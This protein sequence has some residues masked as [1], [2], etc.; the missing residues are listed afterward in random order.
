MALNKLIYRFF[1]YQR[2]LFWFLVLAVALRSIWDLLT[3]TIAR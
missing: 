3:L 2:E 1:S